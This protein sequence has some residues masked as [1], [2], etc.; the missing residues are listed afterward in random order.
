MRFD[1][2]FAEV[3]RGRAGIP[4]DATLP[5]N[6]KTLVVP[7]VKLAYQTID[8]GEALKGD[9][10]D[11]ITAQLVKR[12]PNDAATLRTVGRR[13]PGHDVRLDLTGRDPHGLKIENVTP[14]LERYLQE[15]RC[16]RSE[17]TRCHGG[18]DCSS[19]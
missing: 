14:S 2:V 5:T 9:V 19:L 4:K 16:H 13:L 6:I 3:C 8:Y 17:P 11:S 1:L 12:V 10:I 7:S 18:P 15:T